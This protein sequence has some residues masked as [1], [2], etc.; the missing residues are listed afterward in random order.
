MMQDNVRQ[1]LEALG[2]DPDRD[3][4]L[5]TPK[6]VQHMLEYLTEGNKI[7]LEDVV[8]DA[9]FES[10]NNEMV[11]VKDISFYSLCEHHLIPFF[12]KCHVGYIPNGKVI[13]LSKIPRIVDMFARR[14]QVQENLTAQIAQAVKEAT[15]SNDVSVVM[16]ARH[17]CM[18]MRGVKQQ[19]ATTV[20]SKMLGTFGTDTLALKGD[21]FTRIK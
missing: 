11:I 17:M 9:L 1:I 13:G 12:G 16:E 2:E 7:R 18:E 4:L 3:G 5:K 10:E 19:G 8:N 14:L 20:T 6:R 21:F 15:G